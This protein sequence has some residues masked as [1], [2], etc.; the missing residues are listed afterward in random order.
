M[1]KTPDMDVLLLITM[2]LGKTKKITENNMKLVEPVIS[3]MEIKEM[4]HEAYDY[5]GS[6][7]DKQF[8]DL[9]LEECYAFLE[10]NG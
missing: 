9:D 8:E 10:D 7:T 4:F 6:I 1:L 3:D 2:Y 5:L